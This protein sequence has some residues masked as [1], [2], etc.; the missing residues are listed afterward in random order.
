[1]PGSFI[2]S[3]DFELMWGVR[4]HRTIQDYGDAILGVRRV[5]PSLLRVF[6]QRDIAATWATVG[7]LMFDRR[8]ELLDAFPSL[9]PQYKRGSLSPYVDF[10]QV[11]ASERDDPFHFGLSLLEDIK[12][13]PRQEIGTHTF[14]HYY[15]LEPTRNLG[16]FAAD[17]EAA[18]GVARARGIVPKSIVF[19]RNQYDREH[20]SVCWDFGIHIYRGNPRHLLY[21][22]IERERE[23]RVRRLTRLLDSY[24]SLSGH[25]GDSSE[26]VDGMINVPASRFLRPFNP[27]LATIDSLKLRRIVQSMTFCAERGLS[28]HLWFHPHNFGRNLD[29]NLNFMMR[30]LDHY[31]E[32]AQTHD[33]VSRNMYEVAALQLEVA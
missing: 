20:L 28:Y 16:S 21:Q 4:D 14:S 29:R 30:I 13:T 23:G 18:V 25:N 26:C 1:M 5:I 22:P 24:V 8:D 12:L 17:L 7:M 15:C 3:L 32:L 6:E 11:G 9:K 19:P 33:W 31:A 10:R 2:I 27:H